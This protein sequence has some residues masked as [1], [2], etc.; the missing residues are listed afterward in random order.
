MK[1]ILLACVL[2]MALVSCQDS[3]ENKTEAYLKEAWTQLEAGDCDA[4]QKAYDDYIK[5]TNQQQPELKEAIDECQL[6]KMI[7]ELEILGSQQTD[8][9]IIPEFIPE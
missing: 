7:K 9:D 4:A 5:A 6:D 2:M 8:I 1:K 3:Q